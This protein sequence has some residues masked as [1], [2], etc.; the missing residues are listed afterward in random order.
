MTR[1]RTIIP[2]RP[3]AH[4]ADIPPAP[5]PTSRHL[6]PGP[7]KQHTDESRL[8]V[9]RSIRLKGEIADCDV[10][11]VEGEVEAAI[12][13]RLL[14]VAE[15]GV[16]RG[17]ANVETADVRGRVDGELTAAKLLRIHPSGRVG[18]RI[19]Y[20]S[21]EVLPGGQIS[22]DVGVAEDGSVTTLAGPGAREARSAGKGES[23]AAG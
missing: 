12:T 17:S 18:G 7:V 2:T 9:G 13:A 21:L 4:L 19:V 14:E 23:R 22:G 6:D 11:T 8:I 20:G 3:A 10:L 1:D 16:F 5:T 15:T